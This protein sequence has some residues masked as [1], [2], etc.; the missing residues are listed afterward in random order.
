MAETFSFGQPVGAIVQFAYV[1]ADIDQAMAQYTSRMGVGPWFVRGPFNPPAG[2]YR[3]EPT[4]VLLTL[5][6]TFVGNVMVELVAQLDDK[7]SVYMETV[8]RQG[9]GFHHW[10]IGTRTID[11]DCDRYRALGYEVAFS[12][13]RPTGGQVVYFDTTKDL[14]GMTELI[15]MTPTHEA[16]YAR[17]WRA[18]RDWDGTKTIR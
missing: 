17:M 2:I 10:G 6:R 14:A 9:Y 15:E 13:E 3:G 8:Q 4:D 7:P 1:V 18:C 16:T 12:D 5:A 11:E